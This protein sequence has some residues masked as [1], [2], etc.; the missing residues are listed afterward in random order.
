MAA[1]SSA[2]GAS[3]ELPE[4][5]RF[6]AAPHPRQTLQFFGHDDAER[7]LFQLY[8]SGR[9]PQAF[10]IGGPEGAGKATLAWRLARY[11]LAYP[12]PAQFD[13]DARAGLFVPED[14]P[15][16]RQ[17]ASLSHPD[18][19]LLRRAW[20]EKS[21]K[22]F[23]EIR[24]DDVRRASHMFHRAAGRDGFRICIVD[25]AEDLNLSCANAL[26]KLIEEPPPRSIFLIVAHRPGRVIATIRSRCRKIVLAPPGPDDLAR[27]VRSLGPPWSLADDGDLSRAIT[28]G[29]GS[30]HTVL[31]RFSGQGLAFDTQV[32]RMLDLLPEIDWREV[33]ALA[34]RIALPGS[35]DDFES[36]LGSVF[37]W[38]QGRVRDSAS[39]GEGGQVRRLA[40]YAEVW[41][42]VNEAV[43]ETETFNLDK[44]PLVM[45][46]FS[47]LAAAS[48]TSAS[49]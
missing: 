12:D 1:K 41:E 33:H 21:K 35:D 39:S 5:D 42:R 40:P 19:F 43:R 44:R 46:I 18:L 23:S 27:I 6:D 10:L 47:G 3:D 37:D 30:L 14:H 13:A 20:N 45:S 29:H 11:L 8:A 34:D 4:S 2:A 26:L 38:L 49:P 22:L 24:V 25:S 48:R 7:E 16:A 15:A 28:L 31:R 36:M 9:M 17:T 32:L